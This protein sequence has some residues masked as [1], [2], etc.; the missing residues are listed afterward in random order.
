[1][2]KKE[3]V[4]NLLKDIKCILSQ[5][6]LPYPMN[7]G[8]AEKDRFIKN[9]D[10]T[11]LD[12][13]TGLMWGSTLPKKLDWNNAVQAC[14]DLNFAG[15]KDWRLPTVKELFSIVDHTKGAENENNEPAIDTALFSDTKCSWY[16]TSTPTAWSSGHAWF[17]DF[18]GGGVGSGDRG[19]SS[20][21]RPVRSKK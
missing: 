4:L 7:R 6:V 2:E 16:W 1:M 18:D 11:V 10:G 12:S 9:S 15:H 21:V 17:V 8:S 20:Y 14:K 19:G 13:S 3:T 5:T